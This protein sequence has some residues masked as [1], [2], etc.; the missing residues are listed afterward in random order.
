MATFVWAL[1]VRRPLG[2]VGDDLSKLRV[3]KLVV[4]EVDGGRRRL[5]G[6]AATLGGRRRVEAGPGGLMRRHQR[7]VHGVG[8]LEVVVVGLGRV[9]VGEHLVRLVRRLLALLD[10]IANHHEH[11]QR[12]RQFADQQCLRSHEAQRQLDQQEWQHVLLDLLL[13]ES[14]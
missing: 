9:L 4:V 1:D 11:G 13:H 3:V 12:H 8:R 14:S 7:L 5:P 2:G 10:E 6:D